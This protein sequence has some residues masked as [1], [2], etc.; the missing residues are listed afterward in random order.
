MQFL[1]ARSGEWGTGFAK[2]PFNE[3]VKGRV[4]CGDPQKVN[5]N[6]ASGQGDN[7]EGQNERESWSL[8]RVSSGVL[9]PHGRRAGHRR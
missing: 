9:T 6:M 3:T 8:A 1:S 7:H 5:L 4:T 2:V